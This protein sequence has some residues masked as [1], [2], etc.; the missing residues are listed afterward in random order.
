MVSEFYY[1]CTLKVF[2]WRPDQCDRSQL[3]NVTYMNEWLS[4]KIRNRETDSGRSYL[5]DNGHFTPQYDY[6]YGPNQ[7]RMLDYVLFMDRDEFHSDFRTLMQAYE[8]PQVQLKKINALGA[9]A[10][11][12][13]HLD[14]S[15]LDVSTLQW[16]HNMYPDDFTLG[17]YVKKSIN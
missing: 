16:I 2:D 12:D 8:L 17:G 6:I 1:I 7:V 11:G 10:R 13:S 14:T 5:I 15:H 4:K 3:S 9:V